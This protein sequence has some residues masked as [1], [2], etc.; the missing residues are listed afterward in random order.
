MNSAAER[1]HAPSRAFGI[2]H[3]VV[4]GHDI[5]LMVAYE[6]GARYRDE[7]HEVVLMDASLP[8]HRS[9]G[10][11]PPQFQ[12]GNRRVLP[13]A[14]SGAMIAAPGHLEGRIETVRP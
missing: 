4:V 2:G 6:Y 7:V 5:G 3:V 9:L 1:L 11:M 13:G 12:L 14:P 8:G 10:G